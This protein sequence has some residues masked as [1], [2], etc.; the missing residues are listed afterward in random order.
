M[1]QKNI[2]VHVSNSKTQTDDNMI[3]YTQK[4]QKNDIKTEHKTMKRMNE[5]QIIE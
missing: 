3:F 5:L 2:F 1:I 4:S